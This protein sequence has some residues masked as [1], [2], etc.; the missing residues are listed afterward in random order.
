MTKREQGLVKG[1]LR[2]VFSRSDL[3]RKIVNLS[4][5]PEHFDDTRKRV[6]TWCAC[7]VCHKFI[8]KSYMVVDHIE[9]VIGINETL[10]SLDL[11]TVVDR[12]WCEENNLLAICKDCHKIKTKQENKARRLA[13]KEK[14]K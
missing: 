13:K 12:L 5:R 6:K 11:N 7:P 4:V 10:D 3:R 1:S 14:R 2:R 9:P 8:A